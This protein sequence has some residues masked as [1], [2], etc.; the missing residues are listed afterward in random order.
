VKN[1]L[2]ANTLSVKIFHFTKTLFIMRPLFLLLSF[3]LLLP[4][5]YS[6]NDNCHL[7]IGTNLAGASDYGS[8]YPFVNLFKN[9]RW[10]I[11]HNH[12]DWTGGVPWDPWDTQLSQYIPLDEDGYPLQVPFDAPGA[13]TAQVVRTVWANTGQLA[14]GL[15]VLLYDGQGVIDFW[16]DAQIVGQEPGRIEVQ[17]NGGPNATDGIMAMEIMESQAGDHLRNIRLLMPGTEDTYEGNP[18]TQAWLDKLEPFDVLRFMDWGATNNSELHNWE[19]RPQLGDATYTIKGIPYEKMIEICNLKQ[20]DAWVCIPHRADDDYVTQMATLFRD[21]LNPD[22]KLYVEYSNEV[23]NWLFT[24]AQYGLDSLDQS[25]EWP[26]RLAPRIGHVMQLW[27]DV[28]SDEPDRLVRVL[29]TQHG[30]FDIGNR[31][32]QQ[33]ETEGQDHLIDA[34]SPAAYM[35]IDAPQ[36]A[37]LG[38][39]ATA[40]D[41]ISGAAAFTFD[42]AEYPMQGWKQHAALAAAKGKQLVYYEGGQHFTPDPWGT[43]Q[44]YNPALMAAQ[45]APEMYDLYQQLFDTLAALTEEETLMMHFSFISP[46]WEDPN[47]G[48]YGNFGAL[49]SQFYQFE[50]YTDAPKYRA[51]RDHIDECATVVSTAQPEPASYSLSLFPNPA[52]SWVRLTFD[53]KLAVESWE[54]RDMAGRL[55]QAGELQ[56]GG[57][58]SLE[59]L[60]SGMYILHFQT[61]EGMISRKLMK[62]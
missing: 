62:Q 15:Y 36:L 7:K 38:A 40:Q 49:T 12:P 58:L 35:A 55:V 41:V 21:N 19:D 46:L 23:W 57:I 8:E 53:P 44:P 6:Q 16:G 42:P 60:S 3:F 28:F 5:S 33:L 48:A 18:W 13:D 27:S 20:A 54:V 2:P 24:Q 22:L 61:S 59:G 29:G 56:P 45:E 52:R 34:I 43:V 50:P 11:T 37:S 1:H 30:W 9:S 39:A 14:S 4:F 32:F 10:W 26:E 25:L 17:I 31:I 51:L 47:E